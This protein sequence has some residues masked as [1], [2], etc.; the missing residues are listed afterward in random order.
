MFKN[1]YVF[2]GTFFYVT[3]F[4]DSAPQSTVVLS[5]RP[6]GDN[7]VKP[8]DETRW[9]VVTPGEF[10]MILGEDGGIGA[11]IHGSTVGTSGIV[12]VDVHYD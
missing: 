6:L 2:N 9:R 1:L 12:T 10:R 8:A 7:N 11:R 4:P 3:S 5:N